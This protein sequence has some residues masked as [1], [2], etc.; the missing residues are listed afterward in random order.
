MNLNSFVWSLLFLLIFG[1]NNLQK[2][3]IQQNE[4]KETVPVKLDF[5]KIKA[6]G[7]ITAIVENSSTSYL[8]YKGKPMGYEY[9]LLQLLAEHLQ[10]E[11]RIKVMPNIDDAV[12][13]L[14]QGKG[15]IIAY[16]FTVTKQRKEKVLFT[17]N[18]TTTRQVLVQR[19]PE[20]WEKMS[21]KSLNKQLLRNQV[22]LIGKEIYVRHGSSYIHRLQNLSDEIG[23]DIIVLQ[24]ERELE[25]EEI[26]QKVADGEIDYTVSDEQIALVNSSYYP[27]IDVATPISFPQQIAWAVRKNS[28]MLKEEVDKWID[29]IKSTSQFQVIFNKYFKVSR[30]LIERAQS[31]FSSISGM[32]ISMYDDLIKQEAEKIGWDWMMFS[33]M[34]YQESR[35]NAQANSWAG[36]KG[37]MQLMPTTGKRFGAVDLY[38]PKQNIKAGAGYIHYLSKQWSST[39]PD[40]L[41]RQKFVLASYNVGLGHVQ[42]AVK[43]AELLD[44]KTDVW[45]GEVEECM[46]L[47]A[48]P[49][50]FKRKEVK[51]GYCRGN[52]VVN[53]VSEVLQRYNQ[54]KEHFDMNAE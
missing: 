30:S 27:N 20:G 34:I 22:D 17:K 51:Y 38:D 4:V 11:L 9:D 35:F 15:D 13:M 36:A 49:E 42:D 32:R 16:F 24:D 29:E 3:N 37:L 14:N 40:S 6:R 46:K 1:C 52:S 45:D 18:L 47:K 39:V 25:T 28:P 7:Y 43:I 12:E 31:D 19:K 48:R 54:Y 10:V 23:G 33:S 2:G 44:K 21:S 53:Y 41:E 5:E 50:Y 8:I 26:I